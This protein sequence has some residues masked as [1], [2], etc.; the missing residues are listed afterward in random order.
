MVGEDWQWY[1][2]SLGVLGPHE[3]WIPSYFLRGSKAAECCVDD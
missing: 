2:W 3:K 1:C